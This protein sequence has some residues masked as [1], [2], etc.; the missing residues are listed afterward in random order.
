MAQ[1]FHRKT[2]TIARATL[3]SVLILAV[4]GGWIWYDVYWS[5]YTTRVKVATEQPVPFSHKHHVNGLGIDCRYCH[6]SVEKA[7]F[8]GLPS[9]E[10]CMSEAIAVRRAR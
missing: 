6:T 2:N 5:P 7:A 3:A 4:G 8:A 10:T 9:T 1:I